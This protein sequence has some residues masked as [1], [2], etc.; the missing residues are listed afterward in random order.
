M[1]KSSNVVKVSVLRVTNFFLSKI[2]A[3]DILIFRLAGWD[4]ETPASRKSSKLEVVIWN[5]ETKIYTLSVFQAH[6]KQR[7]IE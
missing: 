2:N 1:V 7:F 5:H 3:F 4:S 6:S